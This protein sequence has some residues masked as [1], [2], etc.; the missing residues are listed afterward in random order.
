MVTDPIRL[1]IGS[2]AYA[3]NLGVPG[4]PPLQD[5][6]D[7]LRLLEQA[8]S[9]GVDVVQ[10]ADNVPL[11]SFDATVL[12][13]LAGRSREL[14]LLLEIGVRGTEPERL[15]RCLEIA[16]VLD[17]GLVR[18]I[19]AVDARESGGS[20]TSAWAALAAAEREVA[21]VLPS[22]EARGVTLGFENY[23]KL[24]VERLRSFIDGFESPYIGVCLDPVNSF[25]WPEDPTRV[26]DTLAPVTV[27][28]HVKDF[29]IVRRTHAMG[30]VLEG[31][32]AGAGRL[33]I[34]RLLAAVLR[35][36]PGGF[37]AIVE[38]WP[39]DQGD[40]DSTASVERAWGTQSVAAMRRLL[41]HG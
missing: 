21:E 40:V 37:S 11:L 17:A 41:Q 4:Y 20:G 6:W 10:L 33:D 5:P 30:F 13:D 19:L 39:Q 14:G 12:D 8:G 38:T 2:Y 35:H 3:W 16:T 34:P 1:G 29:R 18:T 25:G 31:A 22:Y 36:R 32:P 23:E 7:A 24:P 15:E 9:L 28:V 26:V 27:N